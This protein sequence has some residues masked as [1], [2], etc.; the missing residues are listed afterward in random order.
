M[1]EEN[2]RDTALTLGICP[3]REFGKRGDGDEESGS[4]KK[5]KL[6][7]EQ[8]AFLEERFK[9]QSTL[10]S[11]SK[12]EI[13]IFLLTIEFA[14]ILNNWV[15]MANHFRTKLKK[16]EVD[17]EL[18]RK[19]FERLRKENGRLLKELQQLKTQYSTSPHEF[20][21]VMC[22]SCERM[23]GAAAAGDN[24]TT[25]GRKFYLDSKRSHL[26]DGPCTHSAAC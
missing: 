1:E 13:F 4:R 20:P 19:C 3:S 8:S 5:L 17:R 26:L 15:D 11:K 10:G 16:T 12:V 7:K 22:P 2:D 21:V 6:T 25:A 14:A 9:E 23:V 24:A 18:L